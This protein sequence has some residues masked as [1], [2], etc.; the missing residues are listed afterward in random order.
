MMRKVI[1]LLIVFAARPYPVYVPAMAGV[2]K[3]VISL[4]PNEILYLPMHPHYEI[5]VASGRYRVVVENWRV[6]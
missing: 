2:Y 3:R 6:R 1:L 4:A 5:D